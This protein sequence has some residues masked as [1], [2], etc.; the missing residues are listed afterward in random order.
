MEEKGSWTADAMCRLD[1]SFTPQYDGDQ[2]IGSP[3]AVFLGGEEPS[4]DDKPFPPRFLLQ[5]II[6]CAQPM[7]GGLTQSATPWGKIFCAGQ[8]GLYMSGIAGTECAIFPIQEL[9]AYPRCGACAQSSLFGAPRH[10]S[11]HPPQCFSTNSVGAGE[12]ALAP[13]EQTV[14]TT[15]NRISGNCVQVRTETCQR[16]VHQPDAHT[17]LRTFAMRVCGCFDSRAPGKESSQHRA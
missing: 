8:T 4:E 10:V 14:S 3:G 17:G 13:C 7:Q 2:E 16:A 15:Q 11:T 6:F 5:E 9:A 12:T 1:A